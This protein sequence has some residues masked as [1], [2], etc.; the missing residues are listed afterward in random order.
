MRNYVMNYGVVTVYNSQNCGS[1]LQ[2]Y[3]LTEYL[4]ANGKQAACVSHNFADRGNSVLKTLRFIAINMLR[5]R[6]ASA[7][8][9]IQQNQAFKRAYRKLKIEKQVD[10]VDCMVL[11]SDT[12]WDVATPYFKNH[13]DFFWGTAF[14][15]KRIISYAPSI[16]YAK[17]EHLDACP[18]IAD[19]LKSMEKVSVRDTGALELL[20]PLCDKEISLVCDPTFLLDQEQYMQ[21]ATEVKEDNFIFLY[22]YGHMPEEDV[23]Q[24]K[25]LAARENLKIITFGS[26]NR[27]CGNNEPYDPLRF[28]GLYS[29]AKYVITNTFHGAVFAHIFR[30]KF[31]VLHSEKPKVIDLLARMGTSDKSTCGG[32]KVADILASDFDYEMI[33]KNIEKERETGMSYLKDV[34]GEE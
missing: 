5:G 15:G 1:Y 33:G 13:H 25:E 3:A 14:P 12:V 23:K 21:I 19:A 26:S 29:K 24:L 27:W 20:Q 10:S 6:V 22:Y 28:L 2:A 7:L 17:K 31:A 8:R 9:P 30:K 18:W 34:L 11:G 32:R 16:G 4:C